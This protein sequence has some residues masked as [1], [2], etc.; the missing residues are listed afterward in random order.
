M[1]QKNQADL[2][3]ND[4]SQPI[5]SASEQVD[6]FTKALSKN[7]EIC[8]DKNLLI[9]NHKTTIKQKEP[10]NHFSR[11]YKNPREKV[12]QKNLIFLEKTRPHIFQTS[13][14]PQIYASYV[15]EKFGV[16]NRYSVF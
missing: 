2:E 12:N 4:C 9:L 6:Y 7:R 5:L 11:E 1:K 16:C 3:L 8:N 13:K 10:I 15:W 14:K